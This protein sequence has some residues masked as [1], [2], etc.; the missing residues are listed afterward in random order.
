V[1]SLVGFLGDIDLAEEAAQEAFAIA[2]ERWPHQ[3]MP[4]HP[5]AWLV[6]TG[7]NRA[8]DRVRRER[9]FASK[10]HMLH[11]D[12]WTATMDEID[13]DE[14]TIGDDR[15]KLIFT[16][17]HPALAVEAQVALTLRALGGLTSQEIARA[18]L[19]SEETMKR[20]LSR[21]KAKIKATGIPFAVPADY[22]LPDRLSAVLAVIYLIF[23][24][25][26]TERGEL[27]SEAIR[28]GQLVAELMTDESEVFG[29]V[30]LMLLHDSR[31]QARVV[32]GELIP[33][34]EQDRSQHDRAKIDA[35]R[36][37]LD[38]ALALRSPVGPYVLQAA[39]ASLQAEENIDW[40]EV[41]ILYGR[42]EELSA[43]PIVSLNR[44]VA[45]AEAYGPGRALEIVEALELGD[46]RY[47]HSTR[48]EL[49]SRVGR[50][51]EA[52]IAFQHAMGLATTDLERRFLARRL[53]EL[54]P[55]TTQQSP[56]P[57]GI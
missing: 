30:A 3:G 31:R 34:G 19:V 42:L 23:N 47:F 12:Q 14:S 10:S 57:S 25:G 45:I 24:E 55:K 8:I 2:A 37:C 38:R 39:I 35:G 48:A 17:C 15:L 32:E 11:D 40:E 46:Y 1:A 56:G 7:R 41:V 16:C 52:R 20:R 9:T 28:L 13:L 18:F 51:D 49:L 44:A 27:A 5:L 22:V 6:A 54:G 43:S 21:A 50:K 33:L 53:S 26:Y 36:A 4:E 29:L